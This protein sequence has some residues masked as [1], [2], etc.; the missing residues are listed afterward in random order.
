MNLNIFR[1]MALIE[2]ATLVCF[3]TC[4]LSLV[5]GGLNI[6]TIVTFIFGSLGVLADMK[7]EEWIND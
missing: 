4:L 7:M 3:V 6:L 5:Q 2:L 1:T